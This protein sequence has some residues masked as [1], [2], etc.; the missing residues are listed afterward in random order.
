MQ[1]Q[2]VTIHICIPVLRFWIRDPELFYPQDSGSRMHFFTDPGSWI[3][4]PGSG[5]YYDENFLY[6]LQKPCYIIFMTL[7]YS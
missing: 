1:S 3:S 5:P 6:Y 7:V 4:D 2:K